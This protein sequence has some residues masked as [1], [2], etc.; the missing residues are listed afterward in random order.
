MNFEDMKFTKS[1]RGVRF[2]HG[3]KHGAA[4]HITMT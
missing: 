3:K 2:S 4:P 1:E